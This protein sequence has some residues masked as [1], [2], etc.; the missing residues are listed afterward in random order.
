MSIENIKD[1]KNCGYFLFMVANFLSGWALNQTLDKK[2]QQ[3]VN[4]SPNK[5]DTIYHLL[6]MIILTRLGILVMAAVVTLS[7]LI[8]FLFTSFF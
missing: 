3:I 1:L 5:W 4:N 6:L 7:Y 2:F 8:R